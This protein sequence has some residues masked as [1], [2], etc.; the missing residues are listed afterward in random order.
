MHWTYLKIPQERW[1][2][3]SNYLETATIFVFYTFT[4]HIIH[5]I[6]PLFAQ[7]DIGVKKLINFGGLSSPIKYVFIAS[8][9]DVLSETKEDA[10]ER[11]AELMLPLGRVL[12]F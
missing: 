1:H 4:R 9:G 8:K 3:N 12:T 6:Y 10:G 2:L 5:L 11:M 7:G